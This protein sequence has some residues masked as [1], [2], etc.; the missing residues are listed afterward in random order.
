MN[1][2]F[3]INDTSLNILSLL[4]TYFEP[5]KFTEEE[6]IVEVLFWIW[7]KFHFNFNDTN[8]LD[9]CMNHLFTA[10]KIIYENR[11]IM[12]NNEFWNIVFIKNPNLDIRIFIQNIER[13]PISWL[14][15][16]LNKI[17]LDINNYQDILS[18]WN[19]LIINGGKAIE[20][21]LHL[22]W[23]NQFYKVYKVWNQF[24]NLYKHD[25]ILINH[26]K[27]L[28]YQILSLINPYLISS[29]L[30]VRFL[31]IEH[32]ELI[33][34]LMND[35][36]KLNIP[37][38]Y[39]LNSIK[40]N[41]LYNKLLHE[42]P[43]LDQSYPIHILSTM[44]KDYAIITIADELVEE[45]KSMFMPKN[46]QGLNLNLFLDT[47]SNYGSNMEYLIPKILEGSS[48]SSIIKT[49][50]DLFSI[51]YENVTLDNH[52]W[53]Q[54]GNLP[55]NMEGFLGDPEINNLFF[56]MRESNLFIPNITNPIKNTIGYIFP[57]HFTVL[58][59]ILQSRT[60]PH[61]YDDFYYIM[62]KLGILF[63]PLNTGNHWKLI[64]I[65]SVVKKVF[66]FD[67]LGYLT[68]DV[69]FNLLIGLLNGT[70]VLFPFSKEQIVFK[71]QYDGYNCGVWIFYIAVQY[72]RFYIQQVY[73]KKDNA[74]NIKEFIE[75]VKN[76]VGIE[77][78]NIFF[79]KKQSMSFC[80]QLRIKYTQILRDNNQAMKLLTDKNRIEIFNVFS[81]TL[82]TEIASNM[83]SILR[84]L[85]SSNPNQI[86]FSFQLLKLASI[87][88]S[89]YIRLFGFDFEQIGFTKQ[90]V[91]MKQ[92]L[93]EFYFD[94]LEVKITD[95]YWLDIFKKIIDSF[96]T[97]RNL[98]VK[99]LFTNY[100][101]TLPTMIEITERDLEYLSSNNNDHKF[102]S[103]SLEFVA[104]NFKVINIDQRHDFNLCYQY[105]Y[106]Y[107]SNNTNNSLINSSFNN[108]Q[109]GWKEHSPS[110]S[111]FYF[112]LIQT[113]KTPWKRL[114][115]STPSASNLNI[116][117]ANLNLSNDITSNDFHI[118]I[119][120]FPNFNQQNGDARGAA[121]ATAAALFKQI[122]DLLIRQID[123]FQ[124]TFIKFIAVLAFNDYHRYIL[125][126]NGFKYFENTN[127]WILPIN[128]FQ[129]KNLG[130]ILDLT[131]KS[132][133]NENE[134][135]EKH[136][137]DYGPSYVK[138]VKNT[139]NK[140]FIVNNIERLVPTTHSIATIKY[141]YHWE[142]E[143]GLTL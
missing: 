29:Y 113:I 105:Y 58:K 45:K 21:R 82:K 93:M 130:N 17:L 24:L 128:K 12:T 116:S 27:M 4:C 110:T 60:I 137:T 65:D 84:S 3:K 39:N 38:N 86:I 72:S 20:N 120:Y 54:D 67:P 55:T 61:S 43:F 8:G 122:I 123:I 132:T 102:D 101:T 107:S 10:V 9:Q 127:M 35:N 118:F 143:E 11:S 112:E 28:F 142:I 80:A 13:I 52:F 16:F 85:L 25:I 108:N 23:K 68:E 78:R 138:I 41:I 97:D 77:Q 129:F 100:D 121:P 14:D 69:P 141:K 95:R 98:I 1:Y 114:F 63:L 96:M 99:D 88:R 104:D 64:I 140:R 74:Y 33:C 125:Y 44:N 62:N 22:H 106:Y 15:Y 131:Y 115:T 40:T 56:L 136:Y 124:Y 31:S 47:R 139:F 94:K 133:D 73:E 2:E 19:K 103:T 90:L 91:V 119:S 76:S 50:T 59:Q 75:F 135:K 87:V 126:K 7:N 42:A 57:T 46:V 5:Y 18:Q 30:Y 109:G 117:F 37:S 66:Y 70:K 92:L 53:M 26:Y 48:S 81:A 111:S 36:L 51:S 6:N 79:I 32:K 71:T 34:S 134:I 89:F 49:N 83:K